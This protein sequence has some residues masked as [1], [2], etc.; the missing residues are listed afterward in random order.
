MIQ[1][2]GWLANFSFPFLISVKHKILQIYHLK[3]E[4]LIL[5]F[6]YYKYIFI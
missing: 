5:D 6:V 3:A 1:S 2:E 4:T